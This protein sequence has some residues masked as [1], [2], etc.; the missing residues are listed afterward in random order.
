MLVLERHLGESLRIGHEIE[1]RVVSR[2]GDTITLE[3]QAP[4]GVK[5]TVE[6]RYDS[7]RAASQRPPAPQPVALPPSTLPRLSLKR[8]A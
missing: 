6:R 4:E 5:A 1:L 8:R 7:R 2:Q 3:L